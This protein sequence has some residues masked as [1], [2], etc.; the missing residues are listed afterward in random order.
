MRLSIVKHLPRK[1]NNGNLSISTSMKTQRSEDD[2]S[3]T[4]NSWRELNRRSVRFSDEVCTVER[5]AFTDQEREACFYKGE[6]IRR[7]QMDCNRI[8]KLYCIRRKRRT[9]WQDDA[10]SI[11]GIEDYVAVDRRKMMEI[12]DHT[13]TI[14]FGQG[15][16]DALTLAEISSRMSLPH[17]HEAVALARIDASSGY[18]KEVAPLG[19]RVRGKVSSWSHRRRLDRLAA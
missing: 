19:E 8:G 6:D 18:R 3:S 13:T 12:A 11:R 17:K 9:P 10:Q 5:D 14:I 2:S 16:C 1:G 15:R 7:F 4:S